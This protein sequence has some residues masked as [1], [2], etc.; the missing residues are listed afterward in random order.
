MPWTA[1]RIHF[2]VTKLLAGLLNFTLGDM[3]A[4]AAM[5]TKVSSEKRLIFPRTKSEMRVC[6]TPNMAA[7]SGWVAALAQALREIRPAH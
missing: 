7:A 2:A 6:V 1:R 5:S 4:V 3:P